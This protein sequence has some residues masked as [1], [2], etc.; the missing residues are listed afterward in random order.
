MCIMQVY[1][2]SEQHSNSIAMAPAF[3]DLATQ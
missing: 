2:Y 1:F 3:H